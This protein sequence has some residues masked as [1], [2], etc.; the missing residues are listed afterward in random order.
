VA[1]NTLPI[2]KSAGLLIMAK[3]PI[4]GLVKTRLSPPCTPTEAAAVAEAALRD[5]LTSALLCERP[6]TLALDGPPGRWLPCG[7]RVVPQATGDFNRRL[8]AAWSCLPGGGVQIG[9]D[10]PQV[11]PSMLRRA[12]DAV[13]TCGSVF[14]PASDGG[15]W[16]LGLSRPYDAIFSGV[17]MS[18]S[19]T[20]RRQLERMRQLGLR[21]HLLPTLTDIDTWTTARDVATRIPRSRT[22]S[23]VA[24][25]SRRL[26]AGH[27]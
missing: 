20:G 3:V 22:A 11:Q 16:L 6:V 18:T 1:P 4:P 10:T 7:V 14:G 9:M 8:A 23:V 26:S 5:T 25:I 27:A 24:H 13:Q 21:P 12:L 19:S 15:W 2:V 17:A